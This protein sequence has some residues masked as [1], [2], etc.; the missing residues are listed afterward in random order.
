M[1]HLHTNYKYWKEQEDKERKKKLVEGDKPWSFEPPHGPLDDAECIEGKYLKSR[2]GGFH[3]KSVM[4]GFT[5]G[6]VD[7]VQ[8]LDSLKD[9]NSVVYEGEKLLW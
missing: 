5:A 1:E 9:M 3:Q 7:S 8:Q 2:V 4:F 6:M